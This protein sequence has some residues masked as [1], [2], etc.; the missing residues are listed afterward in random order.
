MENMWRDGKIYFRKEFA[1]EIKRLSP[2]VQLLAD[3]FSSLTSRLSPF[4]LDLESNQG[5]EPKCGGIKDRNE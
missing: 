1:N 2:D 4:Q 3:G 5:F